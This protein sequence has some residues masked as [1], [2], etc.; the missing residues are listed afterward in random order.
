MLEKLQKKISYKF[1]DIGLLKKALQHSSYTNEKFLKS[2]ESNERLEFLGDALLGA[3]IS[4]YLF[5]NYP[6]YSEGE[7]SIVKANLVS[8]DLLADI[9]G[10][11]S[12]GEYLRL[13]KGE[14]KNKARERDSML[15]CAVEALIGAIYLDSNFN[16]VRKFIINLF[17]ERLKNLD[18]GKDENKRSKL[19]KVVHLK[20]A[21][22][23]EYKLIKES[24]PSHN[25]EFEI[26]V[27]IGGKV[28]GKGKASSKK[29]AA[30]EA[31]KAA[32]RKLKED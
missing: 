9:S 11:I 12:L 14:E 21:D 32:L 28:Y 3:V 23:P 30:I 24:G 10:E 1:K 13:G 22:E 17:N 6:E 2:Q 5:L 16:R 19:Q 29:R 18:V 26:A 7:L 4:E 20:F 25:K 15:A 27:S 8:R 31:A